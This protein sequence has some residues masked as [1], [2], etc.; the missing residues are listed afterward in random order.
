MKCVFCNKE[1]VFEASTLTKKISL[2]K[3]HLVEDV[4]KKVK[5]AVKKY[6]LISKN[7]TILIALSG[8]KDSISLMHVLSKNFENKI[9]AV[10]VNEGI[11]GY[12]DE[13]IFFAKKYAKEFGVKHYVIEFKK[14]YG[15]SMDDVVRIMNKF[16]LKPC[17]YCGVLRRQLIN[18][19][20]KKMNK[21][22]DDVRLATAHTL[23]DEVQSILMN[24][25]QNDFEKLMRCSAITGYY[26]FNNGI[27]PKDFPKGFIPRIKPYRLVSEKESMAYFLVNNFKT[28]EGSC[29]NISDAYRNRLRNALNK[30]VWKS[31]RYD[32]KLNI[33]NWFDAIL[34]KKLRNH[35]I[36]SSE[37][38]ECK[39]C[40]EPTSGEICKTCILIEKIKEVVKNEIKKE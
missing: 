38:K 39:I 9:I 10:S 37:L 12:R 3:K 19:F 8:G 35:K 11:K 13:S 27:K 22:Y 28:M 2:C 1:A 25:F 18:K 26:K 30:Y 34:S 16:P 17:S 36:K 20:A 7:T 5:L 32:F 29:P 14:E 33:L 4:S 15:F 21:K 23:D 6:G 40:G 31:R 24:I